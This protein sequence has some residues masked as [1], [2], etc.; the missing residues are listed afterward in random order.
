MFAGLALLLTGAFV[1]FGPKLPRLPGDLV[2]SRGGTT[3]HLPIATSI[4]AS[5]VLSLVLN[6][7]FRGR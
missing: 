1:Y 4:V 3:F 7:I 6:L 2:F 5:I